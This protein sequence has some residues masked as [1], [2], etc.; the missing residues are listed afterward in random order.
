MRFING[1]VG[2]GAFLGT[3]AMG[4]YTVNFS[5]RSWAGRRIAENG[6]HQWAEAV[7]L[8]F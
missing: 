7:L 4:M 3:L 2:T 1:M 8:G 6:T 5:A